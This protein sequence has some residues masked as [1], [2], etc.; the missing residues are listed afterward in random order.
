MQFACDTHYPWQREE[1]EILEEGRIRFEDGA[2]RIPN[3][4]GL[5]AE[6]DWDQ[7]AR[8]EEK[9]WKL[10]YR[11]RDDAE[12]MRKHR[13]SV[14]AAHPAPVVSRGVPPPVEPA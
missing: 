3:R 13:R 8:L 4:P 2:V 6:V 1:D 11:R 9:Y 14:L 12:E 7:V 10:P 5:G